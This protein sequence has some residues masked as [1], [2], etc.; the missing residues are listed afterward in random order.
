MEESNQRRKA[1]K[2]KSR[3]KK[4][5]HETEKLVITYINMKVK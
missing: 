2:I 4:C 5:F 1:W 3:K